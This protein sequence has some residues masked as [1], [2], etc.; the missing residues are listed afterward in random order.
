MS[1]K[2]S[3]LSD[4]A[5]SCLEPWTELGLPGIRGGGPDL[6]DPP[7]GVDLSAGQ[8]PAPVLWGRIG[9]GSG[10]RISLLD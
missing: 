1:S 9:D 2:D 10:E 5:S 8:P 6:G 4:P 7:V 3:S